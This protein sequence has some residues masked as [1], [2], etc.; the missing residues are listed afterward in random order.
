MA[1]GESPVVFCTQVIK[2][3]IWVV[4][5]FLICWG[6]RFVMEFLLKLHLTSF[7]TQ[8]VY[9]LKVALFL[10]PFVHAVLNPIFYLLLSKNIRVSVIKQVRVVLCMPNKPLVNDLVCIA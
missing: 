10:L 2:M 9:W 6:P 5:L 1:G 7:F 3:L 4:L 8:F